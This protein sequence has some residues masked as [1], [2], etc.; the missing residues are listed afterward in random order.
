MNDH[1]TL[2]NAVDDMVA[3]YGD[4]VAVVDVDGTATTYVQLDELADRFAG[5]LEGIGIGSG[6]RVGVCRS[7][8][9]ETVAAFLGIMRRGAA[10][11]PVDPFSPP[12]RNQTIFDDCKVSAIILGHAAQ[13]RM[14]GGASVPV[15]VGSPPLARATGKVRRGRMIW[16]TSSTPRVRP[17][18]PRAFA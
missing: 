12:A 7:K 2:I 16:P 15:L 11:V 8:S 5:W 9:V 6:D 3:R 18:G 17:V 10:Y 4:R 14:T 1:S 13:E